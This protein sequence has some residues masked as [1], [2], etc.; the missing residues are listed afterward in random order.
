MVS[1][2]SPSGTKTFRQI[3]KK[4]YGHFGPQD[5]WP[6]DTVCEIIVGAI[7]TQNTNWQN[8]EKAIS[9]LKKENLLSIRKL[10]DFPPAHLARLIR[11]S[12]YFNIKTQR[13]KN[14]CRFVCEQYGG[15]LRKMGGVPLETLR[16]Q[17]LGINGIGPETADSILLYGFRKPVFVVDAYTQRFLRRHNLIRKKDDYH[18]VQQLFEKNLKKDTG[19]FNE[20]HALI[21]SLGKHF[22]KPSPKC[23][24][25]PLK[26]VHYSLE[27]RCRACFRSFL[28]DEKPSRN[29][30]CRDPACLSR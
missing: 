22:C 23:E 3:Y 14:F 27:H 1:T 4:L 8:V 7:L 26:E 15:S 11:P 18:A 19:L 25:C 24:E 9:N 28:P 10:R 17:L 12:G 5:W 21:V 16:P 30:I 6:G 20:Y 13:L 2:T 29:K